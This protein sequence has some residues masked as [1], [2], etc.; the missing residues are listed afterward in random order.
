MTSIRVALMGKLS[1]GLRPCLGP[2]CGQ[3]F[4]TKAVKKN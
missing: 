3:N 1:S 2:F 4:L